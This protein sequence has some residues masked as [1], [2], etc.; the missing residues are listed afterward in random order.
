MVEP[1]AS[2]PSWT[3]FGQLA[4]DVDERHPFSTRSQRRANQQASLLA[5][6]FTYAEAHDCED[7]FKAILAEQAEIEEL[8]KHETRL[9][10]LQYKKLK[11][12]REAAD[13][14]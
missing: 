10:R 12:E 13:V 11:R 7:K 9:T 4:L 5:V 3:T 14:Q 1:F 6:Q 8:A 2:S